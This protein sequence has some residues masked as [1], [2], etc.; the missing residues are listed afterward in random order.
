MKKFSSM[1]NT[2]S[3]D[4]MNASANFSCAKIDDRV[5]MAKSA[6]ALF[7]LSAIRL[8]KISIIVIIGKSKQSPKLQTA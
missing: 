3:A 2:F 4:A 7:V 1:T 6:I 5:A 8:I